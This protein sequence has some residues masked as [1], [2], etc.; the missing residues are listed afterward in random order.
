MDVN[1]AIMR[2]FVQLR[3]MVGYA[4]GFG[5][6]AGS[7]GTEIRPPVQSGL[8]RD[9]GAHDPARETSAEEKIEFSAE[10]ER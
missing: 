4:R 1:I 8:R 6:E 5:T 3:E 10:S 2:T 9:S 7:I